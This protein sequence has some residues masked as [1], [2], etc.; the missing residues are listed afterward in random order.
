MNRLGFCDHQEMLETEKVKDGGVAL[1]LSLKFM[2]LAK[3]WNLTS[4]IL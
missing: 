2:F 4:Q 1:R 3:F